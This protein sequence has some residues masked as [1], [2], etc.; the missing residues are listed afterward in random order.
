[1][2][3]PL[4]L[5]TGLLGCGSSPLADCREGHER[6]R[7]GHCHP[8]GP[9][10]DGETPAPDSGDFHPEDTP[11]TGV[12][13]RDDTIVRLVAG[14]QHTCALQGDGRVTC[15]GR[16]DLI[17]ST[18]NFRVK[19]LTAQGWH[20]CVVDLEDHL[21]CWGDNS[22]GQASFPTTG[23]Y[24]KVSA[25]TTHTC[26]I[27]TDG[28]ITCWGVPDDHPDFAH[29]QVS[30]APSGND[31][32]AISSGK[33]HSCAQRA[34][35]T[36]V[37]WG[38][39]DGGSVLLHGD[40]VDVNQVRGVTD[41]P[42]AQLMTYYWGTCWL[43]ERGQADCC[44][45]L[46]GSEYFQVPTDTFKVIEGGGLHSC[47]IRADDTLRCWG[48]DQHEQVSTTPSGT[49]SVIGPGEKHT[50]AVRTSGEVVCWGRNQF[51][52]GTPPPSL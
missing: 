28:E 3:R 6:G 20:S 27:T 21:Y 40:S 24:A 52:E 7:E 22:L 38:P 29:G 42:V 17:A 11:D 48:D 34:D 10:A 47:G 35:R 4:I 36:L 18:P 46:M 1:M 26:A 49:F 33:L 14:I 5:L 2:Q 12:P 31:H 19:E 41:T 8:T 16:P 43:D 50:C 44:G 30:D 45:A 13:P 39:D 9:D 37:C 23:S 25:G 32:V 15:W 51:G